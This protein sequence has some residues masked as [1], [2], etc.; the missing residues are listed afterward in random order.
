MPARLAMAAVS[1]AAQP[2][3]PPPG[4][5]TLPVTIISRSCSRLLSVPNRCVQVPV[6]PYTTADG[7]AAK[8]RA[9][10]SMSGLATL[11]REPGGGVLAVDA[12]PQARPDRPHEPLERGGRGEAE[13]RRVAD[14][15]CERRAAVAVD[16]GFEARG[17]VGQCLVPRDRLEVARRRSSE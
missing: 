4:R 3:T 10:A 8:S 1:T 14:E 17:D 7:A 15:G 9:R 2:K 13:V 6:R 5:S 16:D 11:G 12:V